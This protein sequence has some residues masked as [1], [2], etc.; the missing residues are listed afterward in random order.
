MS[1]STIP[2][3]VVGGGPVGLTMAAELSR[4]GVP[5]RI[6][7]RSLAPSDKSKA[8]AV[9][10]RTLEL[11]DDMGIGADFVA[12]GQRAGGASLYAEGE[13]L[14]HL[15]FASAPTPHPYGLMLPQ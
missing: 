7:D 10:S 2:A 9:W 5:A 1:G 4:H 3:L 13:R 14:V 15:S 11:L 6:I 12:A 8:L